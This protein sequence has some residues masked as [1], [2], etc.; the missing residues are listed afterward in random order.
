MGRSNFRHDIL[1]FPQRFAQ[2]EDLGFVGNG[3]EGTADHAH[4]AGNA[5]FRIDLCPSLLIA[6]DGVHAAGSGA[7]ALQPGDGVIR[8]DLLA[9]AAADAF[10]LID[11]GFPLFDDDS[12]LGADL[13]A[14]MRHASAAHIADYVTVWFAGVAG[15]WNHLHERRL[16]ILFIDVAFFHSGSDM[17]SFV[18]RPQ[19]HTHGQTDPFAG[20]RPLPVDAVA[21]LRPFLDDTVGYRLNFCFKMILIRFKCHCCDFSE[22]FPADFSDRSVQSSHTYSPLTM[23]FFY[24]FKYFTIEQEGLQ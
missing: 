16:I 20:Y 5:F 14:G 10:F 11:D 23:V 2:L 8:A 22:D 19:G 6:F 1:A 15:R 24:F 4:A 18:L 12:S 21:V 7:G 13:A 3:S 17:H 9:L